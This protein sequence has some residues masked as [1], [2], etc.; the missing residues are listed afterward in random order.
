L[1]RS[2]IHSRDRSGAKTADRGRLER[3]RRAAR[4]GSAKSRIEPLGGAHH[5]VLARAI[6]NRRPDRQ[7]NGQ[8]LRVDRAYVSL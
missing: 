5:R 7:E 3:W 4:T 1:S 6:L 8:K 2:K